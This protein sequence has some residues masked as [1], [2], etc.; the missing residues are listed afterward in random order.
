M[1]WAAFTVPRSLLGATPLK[2]R[3]RS[4]CLF[5][6]G[7][8]RS[9]FTTSIFVE[10]DTALTAAGDFRFRQRNLVEEPFLVRFSLRMQAM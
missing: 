9:A 8:L 6:S 2:R 5:A 10:F 1:F 4:L 7:L 3:F